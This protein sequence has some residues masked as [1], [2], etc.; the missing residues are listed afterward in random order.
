MVDAFAHAC[1][2]GFENAASGGIQG[3]D[4]AK[5]KRLALVRVLK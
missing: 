2:S 1:C 3:L 4:A 5:E